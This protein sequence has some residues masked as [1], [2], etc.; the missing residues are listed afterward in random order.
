[1]TIFLDEIG[2]LPQETQVALLRV[3]QEHEFEPVGAARP[4]KSD[5]RVICATNRDLPAAIEA[6]AFR[7]DLF[8]RL[9]VFPIE[10]PSLRERRED[11]PI[12][13]EYFAARYAARLGKRFRSIEKASMERV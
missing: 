6:G 5:V 12:L 10:M 13:V 9:N 4:I 1:G 11:I 3:L 8:Y 2:E 7:S